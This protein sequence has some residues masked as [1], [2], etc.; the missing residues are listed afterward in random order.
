MQK[1]SS[2]GVANWPSDGQIAHCAACWKGTEA[3]QV[4]LDFCFKLHHLANCGSQLDIEPP[5]RRFFLETAEVKRMIAVAAISTSE[6][7]SSPEAQGHC[8]DF[9]AAEVCDSHSH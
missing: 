2:S 7:A 5:N 3:A 4:H 9:S 8:S 6:A 1:K